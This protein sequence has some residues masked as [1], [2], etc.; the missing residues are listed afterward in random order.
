[1][2]KVEVVAAIINFENEIFCVQRPK[3]K[4]NYISKKF[5]FPGGKIEK[6]ESKEEALRRELI[7]ELNF[8]PTKIDSLF[9]TVIHKYPDFELTMHSF[10]CY[11]DTKDIQLNEHIS[12]EW[13]SLKN[14]K[15]LD[16]AEADIPIVNRLIENG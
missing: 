9:L 14:L 3:N 1:M 2:K 11:S 8:I 4:L 13:L 7:E 12:S 16:W 6:G 15:K 5:E 10:N